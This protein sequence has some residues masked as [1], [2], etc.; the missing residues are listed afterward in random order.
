MEW[1]LEGFDGIFEGWMKIWGR[2]DV[3]ENVFRMDIQYYSIFYKEFIY[4]LL[5]ICS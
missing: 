1:D 3:K 5:I 4:Y 2:E